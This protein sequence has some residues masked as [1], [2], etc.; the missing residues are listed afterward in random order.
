MFRLGNSSDLDVIQDFKIL[1]YNVRQFN[2]NGWSKEVRVGERVLSFVKEQQPDVVS[3]QEY[4]PS[5]VLDK[6]IYPHKHSVMANGS[7]SFGQ[8]IFSKYP[9]V[10]KGSL[11]FEKTGN[12]GIYA[13]IATL[14]DTLRVYNMHFQ[15]FSLSPDL[16]SLQKQDSKRLLTRLGLAFEK[17]EQQV[18]KYLINEK[19]SPYPVIVTG[20]FNNSATSY[21][22]RKVKGDK[23]DAFAK[24][25]S[26]T[27]ATFWFDI[28]PLRIDFI[29][30]SAK[31]PVV[32]FEIFDTPL[33][34]H[35]PSMATL[36]IK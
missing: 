18:Q 19:S 16:N 13:D 10:S 21:M 3:F 4:H 33:S 27:G 7:K 6:T 34:D 23:N 11:D 31:F 30:S 5:F 28:I 8:V 17:Q 12:N 15:S 1:T 25:G 2:L 32:N 9:I 22:Y 26:G 20:D 14:T 29:L 24:A 36:K 35:K